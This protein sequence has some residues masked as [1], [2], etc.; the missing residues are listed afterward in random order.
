[1]SSTN[2]NI[3][4]GDSTRNS[5]KVL[6]PPG[7]GTSDIFGTDGGSQVVDQPVRRVKNYQASSLFLGDEPKAAAP[8]TPSRQLGTD[9][10]SRLFGTTNQPPS[11]TKANRMRSNIVFESNGASAPHTNGTSAPET[12]NNDN[13]DSE[14]NQVTPDV[15]PEEPPVNGNAVHLT[16]GNAAQPAA[17]ARARVPPGGFSS[18]LW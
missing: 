10:H 3:G 18:G 17:G 8:A 5:S 1:M 9:S 12:P 6:K 15:T 11:A 14:G 16:N 13:T 4:F 7:G 2:H